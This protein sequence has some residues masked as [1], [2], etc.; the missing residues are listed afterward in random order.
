MFFKVIKIS[1][2]LA[3][4]SLLFTA[5]SALAQL[6]DSKES[7]ISVEATGMFSASPDIVNLSINLEGR[8]EIFARALDLLN[9]KSENITEALLKAGLK[10]EQLF[11]ADYQIRQNMQYNKE[12]RKSEIVGYIASHALTL[13]LPLDNQQIKKVISAISKADANA[14]FHVSFALKDANKAKEKALAN[15]VL[16]AQQKAL[17]ICKA[18][19]LKLGSINRVEFNEQFGGTPYQ[20]LNGAK[21][22]DMEM[23]GNIPEFTPSNITVTQSVKILYNF[24]Q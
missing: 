19:D 8:D 20:R 3:F 15:A 11:T 1:L 17:I 22:Y 2:G 10:K 23:S 14:L 16:Q 13:Q 5:N 18:A 21:K 7:T 12:S 24:E 4:V 9:T 6:I